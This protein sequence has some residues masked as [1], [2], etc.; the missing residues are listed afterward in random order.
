[1][2][3]WISNA[4]CIKWSPFEHQNCGRGIKYKQEDGKINCN[5]KFEHEKSLQQEH[6]E[7]SEWRI[8]IC[9]NILGEVE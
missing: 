1:M 8:K 5:Q 7:K 6:K 9:V 2:R 4:S 3:M